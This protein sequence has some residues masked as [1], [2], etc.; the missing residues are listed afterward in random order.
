ML[1]TFRILA[2]AVVCALAAATEPTPARTQTAAPAAAD[3][4]KLLGFVS[5]VRDRSARDYAIATPDGIDDGRHVELGG[6]AQWITIRG[7]HRA[8]PV[9][10]FLHGGPATR[11]H[12]CA[13][14]VRDSGC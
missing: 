13:A 6:I 1:S 14:G 8:N 10:L 9:V 12:V 4:E 3:V 2:V 5:F 11:R 7:E